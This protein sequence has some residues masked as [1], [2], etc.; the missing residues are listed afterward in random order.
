MK[1]IYLDNSATTALS[2]VVRERM[3]A[4]MDVYGNPSSLHTVGQT[5]RALIEEAR[6]AI[7]TSLG[8]R[9]G[10]GAGQ[11]FFT[12]CG[13]EADNL[14]ILGTAYAKA[15]RRGGYVVTTDSE[16]PGVARAMDALEKDGFHVIRIPTKGGVLDFGAYA[17]A[18]A[19]KPFL[20]SI[21]AVN[22][23]T[24]AWYDIKR[25]FSMASSVCFLAI[26]VS[27]ATC[28]LFAS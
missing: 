14:A 8:V 21:M 3:L 25:A 22:N 2:P 7:L 6:R 13:S 12:S 26:S 16:H 5:A 1:E 15:R 18:L 28:A 11:L 24:G 9:T 4:A 17:Q 27:A 19:K 10:A 20:V 23:K